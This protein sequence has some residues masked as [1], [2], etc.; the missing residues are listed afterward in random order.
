MKPDEYYQKQIDHYTARLKQI[1]KRRNLIT[2]AKLLTFGYMIFLIYLLINHSTQP[3]LLLGIGAILVFIFLT[4]WDSQIIYRQHLIEELLRINTLESDYLAGNFSALDQGERFNDPAHPYAHDLDLFGED[5]LFQHLNRTVTFSGTQ[6][7]VSWLLSLSKDPE[8]IHSRQQ[9]A[10]EL[11]AEPEW[12]QHFRAAGALH[13]T[14]AL[15]AVILKSGP[16]ESP[17]FSKHST[18]RLI[19][20]IANTIVIVSWAVTSFTPLPFSISLVL[21]LL[22]LS[23]LALYIKKINAYHQRLNLFLKTISNYLPLV[24]LIHDQSFRSPYLQ[25]IRHSLFTPESNSLQ[26]LT[27]LHRIQNNLD[28]RGNIVIAFILNGLYLKD[29]H[30]LLRLDHWRKKYGPDIETWTDVLS[31]ADALI[32]MANYR[33]NHPAYCLPVICQDRLLDTEEIGHPLLKSERNVTNDFSIRSLHQIAIVTGANMA[34]KSTFLRTIGV[35]LILAQSGNVVCS[36]YFA[37]QPMTL[38][39]SMRTTDSLSKDT[40]Y[41]HAELLRLQQLVNIAQQEDKVFII[42]DEMLKGT[43][44][45]DK[46]NGSLA[47]LKRILS[48]PISGLV[49]THDLALGELADDFPEHFFNVCFEIVHSGSQITYDYKLHPGISSNMNASI[50]LKQMGLI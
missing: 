20:W 2:L 27:Q 36:R 17:F 24:R 34:G 44:S 18:V 16:T 11:C 4:L 14:Q 29:F 47:F 30:T 8:V 40:S 39:T 9:A 10:E 12:C 15:D 5:S 26:A 48:Y 7:L 43:N 37:F 41:F 1:K 21:S 49:A 35:N 22:Q 28:Q 3:L 13:P 19:L 32:S 46:L 23:A 42:L 6:K 25:K 31:E 38:F 50:L 45:V 33:F